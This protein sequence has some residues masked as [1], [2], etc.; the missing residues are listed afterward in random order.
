M[1]APT[2]PPAPLPLPRYLQLLWDVE[3]S[4][5]R[6][7]KPG[8]SIQEIGAAAVG[9]ADREGLEAVSMKAVAAEL[10]LTT[11]SL[12]RY[13]D[14]K[15]ELG[16][17][18]LDVAYG[19]VGDRLTHRGRWR[20]R[21]EA[22]ARVVAELCREH[23]WIVDISLPG[24]PLTP[25]AI[26]WMEAGVRALA[27]TGLTGQQQL[28][29]L[30]VVD[31]YVRDHVRMCVRFGL[32]GDPHDNGQLYGARL[33]QLIDPA[34]F[35]LVSA[36]QGAFEDDDTDFFETELTF[37]LGLLLDGIGAMVDRSN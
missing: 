36:A 21:L 13:V 35:P 25:N 3:E 26:E 20:T 28:S 16:A 19:P 8:R 14:S 11:M 27:P 15:D 7:P 23:P 2:P 9:L 18:M 24:P 17:V 31:G 37:G 22:W 6:G 4:G 34:R 33:A 29:S 1:P 30:L 12:Y 5:R 32:I 10:G